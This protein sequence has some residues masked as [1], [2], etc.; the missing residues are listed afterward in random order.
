MRAVI[1]AFCALIVCAAA[2]PAPVRVILVGDST[3]QPGS[4]YGQRLCERFRPEVSCV[5]VA[6]GGRS[7]KSFRV[8]GRWDAVLASLREG[9]GAYRDTYVLIQFGHNDAGSVPHR[10]TEIVEFTDNTRAFVREVRAA[11]GT[12]VLVTPLTTRGFR[13]GRV[14]VGGLAERADAV[15]KVAAEEGVIVLDLLKDSMAAVQSMGPEEADTL[16]TAPRGQPGFDTTHVGDKGARVFSAIVADEIRAAI[17]ALGR[18][19]L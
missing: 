16:A 18:W 19:L 8:E 13:D 2:A 5:N 6:K 11:G 10:H 15:R 4:G 12:P 9:K 17:P 14:E 3:V 7:T 1:V